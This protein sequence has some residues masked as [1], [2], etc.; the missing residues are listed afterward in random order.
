MNIIIAQVLGIIFTV[1]GLSLF[2]DRKGLPSVIEESSNS[3]GFW[4]LYGLIA[5]IFGAILIA[6][7]NVWSS[8][9]Q[10]VVTLLGWLAL[11]KGTFILVFPKTASS[12]YKKICK[13]NLVFCA[14]L[15]LFVFGLVLLYA[16]FM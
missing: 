4:W 1:I 11:L 5:L 10:L 3:Q 14:G 12:F 7:N 6:F 16:G 2:V 15:V 8:G 9:L 13:S